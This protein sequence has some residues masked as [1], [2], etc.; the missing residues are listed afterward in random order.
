MDLTSNYFQVFELPETYRINPQELKKRYQALQR[1][2]HPDKFA[3]RG[4]QQQRLAEQYTV[5]LNQAFSTLL[6]PLTRAEYLLSLQG[7]NGNFANVTHQD[8]AFLLEQIELQ[9]ALEAAAGSGNPQQDVDHLISVIGSRYQG[10]QQIFA[11]QYNEGAYEQAL[12]TIAKMH[13]FDKLQKRVSQLEE[14][15]DL[16]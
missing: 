15:L 2:C 3:G 7:I 10:L 13:F 5:F 8:S 16:L 12:E 6:S 11:G 9:E 4:G 1:Q 14:D